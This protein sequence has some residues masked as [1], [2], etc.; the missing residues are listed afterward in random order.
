MNCIEIHGKHKNKHN[1]EGDTKIAAYHSWELIAF[2]CLDKMFLFIQ[3]DKAH[4]KF[5]ICSHDLMKI[6][7][8]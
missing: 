5:P 6:S 2:R 1:N 4:Y 7:G 3:E 8:P